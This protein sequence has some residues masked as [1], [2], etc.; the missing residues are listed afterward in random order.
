MPHTCKVYQPGQFFSGEAVVKLFFSTPA[1]AGRAQV[2]SAPV[3]KEPHPLWLAVLKTQ[4][5]S[6]GEV[7]QDHQERWIVGC[8]SQPL[9][10]TGAAVSTYIYESEQVLKAEL[11]VN[12]AEKYAPST[13]KP[14]SEMK[15]IKLCSE[16]RQKTKTKT[17]LCINTTVDLSIE[18]GNHYLF[19]SCVGFSRNFR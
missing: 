19:F 1:A 12:G 16:R 9:L 10:R 17:L 15:Y 3:M 7:H 6:S 2:Y 14:C 4:G 13:G 5:W 11:R 18:T 8:R